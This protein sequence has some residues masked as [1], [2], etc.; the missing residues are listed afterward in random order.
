MSQTLWIARHGFRY[1]FVDP[2]GWLRQA[3]RPYDPPLAE[4]GI[5]QAREIGEYLA[6]EA[7]AGIFASP[8][9]RTVQT[10]H[11]AA[12]VLD[13]SIQLEAGL[14]EWLN[15][16]WISE[17]PV[18]LSVEVLRQSYPRIDP[19]Y[20]SRLLPSFPESHADIGA[21]TDTILP[22]LADRDRNLLL[23]THAAIVN[24]SARALTGQPI[25]I[26]AS[27]GCL[28]KFVRHGDR[29]ES[30]LTCETA[31]LSQPQPAIAQF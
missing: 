27:C 2:Y 16:D 28:V 10:A 26:A 17:A 29:W 12:E 22:L 8:F 24:G 1:D 11:Y 31:H 21:R 15:P 3:D 19:T 5:V 30:N 14:G 9:L 20:R 6:A 23:V 13:V 25:S 4:D 7:I 18:P